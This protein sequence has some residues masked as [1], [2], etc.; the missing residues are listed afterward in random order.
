MSRTRASL[1]D[2]LRD[3]GHSVAAV[4]GRN[5]LHAL[6]EEGPFDLLVCNLHCHDV[7]PVALLVHT[8]KRAIPT[9]AVAKNY[10]QNEAR[11]ACT[12]GADSV[13]AL[14][15][16]VEPFVDRVSMLVRTVTTAPP[17]F[18]KTVLLIDDDDATRA[19]MRR[20][21]QEQ[22]YHVLE[23]ANGLEG[24]QIASRLRVDM[25]VLDI[26]MPGMDG[27]AVCEV[28][29]TQR[30]TSHLPVLICTVRSDEKDQLQAIAA[31]ADDYLVKP[32]RPKELVRR[33]TRLIGAPQHLAS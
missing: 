2:A 21:L 27:L 14:P 1:A 13:W 28:L 24:I 29:K 18:V 22:G 11:D 12:L 17:P 19:A 3:A 4:D 25:V 31:A 5:S 33:T 32:F 26:V 7:N 15:V 30:T 6:H 10:T 23:A 16:D 8:R 20:P 9:L